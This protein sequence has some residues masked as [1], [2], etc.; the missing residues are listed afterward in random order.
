LAEP[1]DQQRQ[2]SRGQGRYW[3]FVGLFMLLLAAVFY[4]NPPLL[5][6]LRMLAFDTYQKLSPARP[7]PGSPIRVVEIDEASLARLGQWP[8]PRHR[9]AVFR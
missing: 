8:W 4:S 6:S 9:R 5:N 7:L 1:K 2:K 3:L